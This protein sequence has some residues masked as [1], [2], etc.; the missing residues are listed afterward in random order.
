MKKHFYSHLIDTE[1]IYLSLYILDL[2]EKERQELMKIVES[3]VHHVI[4]DTIMSELSE[5]DKK[6]FLTH[7]ASEK[8]DKLWKLLQEKTKNI[9][10]KIKQAVFELKR[11]L[12]K[13][14]RSL[15]S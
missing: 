11:E 15:K 9:E 4:I 10:E 5:E 14:I 12:H 13:D 3:S 7:L 1:S 8:H 2:N 6:I